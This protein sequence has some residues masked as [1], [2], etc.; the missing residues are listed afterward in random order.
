[1]RAAY[2]NNASYGCVG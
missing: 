1:M 2:V